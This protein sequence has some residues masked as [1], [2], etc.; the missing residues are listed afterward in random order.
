MMSFYYNYHSPDTF[1]LISING[2]ISFCVVWTFVCQHVHWINHSDTTSQ[3]EILLSMN[4]SNRIYHSITPW[5]IDCWTKISLVFLLYIY[6][7]IIS[8]NLFLNLF[9]IILPI[10]KY[11]SLILFLSAL[12]YFLIFNDEY[13][14]VIYICIWAII[15]LL[16]INGCCVV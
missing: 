6:Q 9:N 1:Y 16:L 2:F 11:Q 10:L 14:S 13:F 15:V 12:S 7:F 5:I 4:T 8:C 3:T